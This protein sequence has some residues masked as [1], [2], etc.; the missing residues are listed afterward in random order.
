MTQ[1]YKYS[2]VSA[3]TFV[4]LEKMTGKTKFSCNLDNYPYD[5]P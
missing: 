2:A 4:T 5:F 3:V 1:K